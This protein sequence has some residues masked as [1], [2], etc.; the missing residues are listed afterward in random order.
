M[1]KIGGDLNY[2]CVRMYTVATGLMIVLPGLNSASDSS[3]VSFAGVKG[4]HHSAV[5]KV[6][7]FHC[8]K[9]L[10]WDPVAGYYRGHSHAAIC[11]EP[12]RCLREHRRC[13]FVLGKLWNEWNLEDWVFDNGRYTA[14]MIGAGCY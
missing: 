10:G 6:H 14:C 4:I 3:P 5:T 11:Q 12:E 2:F 1:R 9:V 8:R 7:G 13:I